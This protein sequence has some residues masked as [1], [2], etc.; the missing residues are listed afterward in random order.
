MA[1]G[2]TL[3]ASTVATAD[4]CS[5]KVY[6]VPFNDRYLIYRPL[7]RLAFIGNRALV[8]Y[9]RARVRKPAAAPVRPDIETFLNQTGYWEPAEPPETEET[10][11]QLPATAV[12]LMT[13]RCNLACTYCYAA[14]GCHPSADM[15]WPLARAI[16]DIAADNARKNGDDRFE[17]SFHGGGEPTLNGSVLTR[18]VSYA[19]NLSPGCSVSLASNGVW[20][21]QM[22]AF[23]CRNID[24]VTLSFDGVRAVQDAQRPCSN[25]RGSFDAVLG[26]VRALDAAGVKYG[27]RMTVTPDAID[28]LTEGVK[29]LCSETGLRSLQIE[30]SFTTARGLYADPS[31]DDGKRF[32]AAFLKAARFASQNGIFTYYS[33]AR[34][35]VIARA[36]C[37]AS[38][39]AL[40]VTPEG[41]QV[42]CFEATG[43]RHP[44]ID[45]FTIGRMTPGGVEPDAKAKS[46]FT[47][48]QEARRTAC[49]ECFCYW[50]CC[51][52]CDSRAMVSQA[53][54]SVRC[55]INR[56][57]TKAII[58]GWIERFDGVWSGQDPA[59]LSV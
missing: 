7:K 28:R 26:S 54:D 51:G 2:I 34:P 24:T 8:D 58:S 47:A 4:F 16:I 44:Y 53:P 10:V 37:L 12:L 50:H 20:S 3:D 43:D 31:S 41:R 40:I 57:I 46:A 49:R 19:R 56:R 33:G 21:P 29:F 39:Q 35:W 55:Q 42:A 27:I 11:P 23:I 22:R 32:A 6:F 13:N 25:G 36:F 48:R 15:P 45:Q 1:G 9:L 52:D 30:A 38:R 18:A 5:D 14:A 17:L 59:S